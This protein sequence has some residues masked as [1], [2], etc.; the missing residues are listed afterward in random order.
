MA[1]LFL[2]LISGTSM[3][4]VDAALVDFAGG[5]P[6]ILHAFTYPLPDE[7]R[8]QT[9]AF[10][11][12]GYRGDAVDQLGE[13]DV[14]FAEC[15]AQAANALLKQ[16]GV[17][18]DAIAAIGSHGQTVRH[19]PDHDPPFTLQIGDP[20]LIAART[21]ITTVADFRRRDIAEGGQGAPL[22]PAFHAAVLADQHEHRV[23]ANIGGMANI[24]VLPPGGMVRGFDT[25]PGNALLDAWIQDRRQQ[26]YDKN[27]AWAAGGSVNE[28]LLAALLSDAYFSQPPPKSTGREYFNLAWL[29]RHLPARQQAS[30]V[31]IQ[32]TLCELT[33]ITLDQAILDHAPGVRRVL[34]CGGG[35]RNAELLRRLGARLA[36]ATLEDTGRYGLDPDYVEAAGFAW[37]ARETLAGRPGNLPSVTG[38][39]RAV[40]LGSITY[41]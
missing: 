38:A 14:R 11:H 15:F 5:T 21:G 41:P 1:E 33:A 2:G 29:R 39:R 10:A 7:L 25:G 34:V 17:S 40:V 12:G 37:L 13:L 31:D 20:S 3:D 28:R 32:A 16:A 22:M 23:V 36:G 4:A 9:L 30:D 26:P 19:R 6:R 18:R 24:T 27:G 8:Q 35:A